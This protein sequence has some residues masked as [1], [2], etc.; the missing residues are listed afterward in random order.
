MGKANLGRGKGQA[1]ERGLRQDGPLPWRRRLVRTERAGVQGAGAR[2]T[3]PPG[4][5]GFHQGLNC[6]DCGYHFRK[7]TCSL[8]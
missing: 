7:L 4:D 1:S 6:G 3:R 8:C 5:G 2:E